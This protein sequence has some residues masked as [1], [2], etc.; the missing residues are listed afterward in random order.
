MNS[1]EQKTPTANHSTTIQTIEDLIA[2]LTDE[3]RTDYAD[4]INSI[5]ISA[6]DFEAFSTW[7]EESYTRN[8]LVDNERLEL[9]LLCWEPNQVTPIHDHGGEECWVK[10][11]DGEL[12]ETI[13]EPFEDNELEE[14][15]SK[16]SKAGDISYMADFIGFH[17]LENSHNGRSM[18]LH[19][20]AKPIRSC[21]LFDEDSKKFIR[22]E[23]VYD[24]IAEMEM[25][26]NN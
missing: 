3:E 21:R 25:N 23:L 7:S 22:K 10:V 11:I 16:T 24:T 9:I 18:S 6:N 26:L 4:I 19:L 5:A 14:L 13:Y 15:V 1:K 17:R 12:M 8:C 2:E 20:Y